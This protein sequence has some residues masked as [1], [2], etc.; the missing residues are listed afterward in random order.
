MGDWSKFG[1]LKLSKLLIVLSNISL[2]TSKSPESE[3]IKII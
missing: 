3:S 2:I 1:R